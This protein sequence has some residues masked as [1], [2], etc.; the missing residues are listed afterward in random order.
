MLPRND[1]IRL[2]DGAAFVAGLFQALVGNLRPELLQLGV[3][4]RMLVT[5]SSP[6]LQRTW[7]Q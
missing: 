4:L 3:P 1:R 2:A 5:S 7:L 6:S